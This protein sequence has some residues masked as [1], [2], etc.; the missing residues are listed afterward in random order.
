MFSYGSDFNQLWQALESG[1]IE[2]PVEIKWDVNELERD[3][4]IDP[5]DARPWLTPIHWAICAKHRWPTAAIRID[6]E[7]DSAAIFEGPVSANEPAAQAAQAFLRLVRDLNPLSRTWLRLAVEDSGKSDAPAGRGVA[8]ADLVR[9]LRADFTS[10]EHQT[11]RHAVHNLI[12]P[13]ILNGSGGQP[14]DGRPDHRYAT[15]VYLNV[16]GLLNPSWERGTPIHGQ[17][18]GGGG[19]GGAVGRIKL[20][21][22][23]AGH[24][25]TEW[26]RAIAGTDAVDTPAPKDYWGD[27]VRQF[28]EVPGEDG[29]ILLLDLRLGAALLDE[30]R[31]HFLA[32][33]DAW[34][35]RARALDPAVRAGLARNAEALRVLPANALSDDPAAATLMARLVAV[36]YPRVPIIVFSS[37]RDRNVLGQFQPFPN[38]ITDF[39]KG[40]LRQIADPDFAERTTAALRQ[41]LGAARRMLGV[42]GLAAEADECWKPFAGAAGAAPARHGHIELYL[43]ETG[44]YPPSEMTVGG[45]VGVFGGADRA[46]AVNAAHEYNRQFLRR[47]S[48]YDFGTAVRARTPYNKLAHRRAITDMQIVFPDV[49]LSLIAIKGATAQ[50]SLVRRTAEVFVA[51]IS[52]LVKAYYG[53]SGVSFSV[54]VGTRTVPAGDVSPDNSTLYADYPYLRGNGY[55]PGN[56]SDPGYVYLSDEGLAGRVVEESIGQTSSVPDGADTCMEQAQTIRLAYHPR[57]DTNTNTKR[58]HAPGIE[59]VDKVVHHGTRRRE[60]YRFEWR[61]LERYSDAMSRARREQ[62]DKVRNGW[63]PECRALHEVA[64][65]VL[66]ASNQLPVST[67]PWSCSDLFDATE[68][69]M[70]AV[71]R[72]KSG[73][74]DAVGAALAMLTQCSTA[75]A[76]AGH[77]VR[78]LA[79][80]NL[81]RLVAD[82][83]ERVIGWAFAAVRD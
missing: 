76:T 31:Q 53:F 72:M 60:R 48:A 13:L 21:D 5:I 33:H 38:V 30:V 79:L 52:P 68:M 15:A 16:V 49:R 47:F 59:F 11:T 54:F 20:V 50:E 25:W 29:T 55:K 19:A 75:T 2:F 45:V 7:K 73:D 23:Q 3:L 37:T 26:V 70:D 67:E 18:G 17:T 57:Y 22:D 63:E 9:I 40:T 77:T 64:D 4:R 78:R 83:W 71:R 62:D 35:E 61:K 1:P 44:S 51:L 80:A 6:T 69:P 81:R 36:A 32:H 74:Q 8:A 24:G 34:A 27:L 28:P 14:A 82:D 43:D 58:H 56:G 42:S 41:C 39:G 10:D 46:A 66:W 65:K 12:I